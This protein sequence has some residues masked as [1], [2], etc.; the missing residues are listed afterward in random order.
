VLVT[1]NLPEALA[2]LGRAQAAGPASP[3]EL[4]G[5]ALALLAAGARA[6]LLKGGHAAGPESIDLLAQRTASGPGL[7]AIGGPRLPF[8]RRGTGCRLASAL[9][10]GL[11]LGHGVEPAARAAKRLVADYLRGGQATAA[12]AGR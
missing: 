10:A 6:V 5:L 7:C 1:P 4:A 3:D 8:T 11:A 9:A 2:L 12:A